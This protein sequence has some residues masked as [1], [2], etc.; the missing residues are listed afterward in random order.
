MKKL[1]T[2]ITSMAAIAL[3]LAPGAAS[4]K[5]GPVTITLMERVETHSDVSDATAQRNISGETFLYSMISAFRKLDKG[6]N[7]NIYFMNKYSID[8]ET[9]VSNIAGVNVMGDITGKWK[10]D[11]GYSHSASPNRVILPYNDSDRFALSA[12]FKV[13]PKEKKHK[14]V[15]FKTSY[16]TGTDFS[17]GRTL[18]Q[19]VQATDDIS[20]KLA[21]TASYQFVWGLSKTNNAAGICS[22]CREHYANQYA[23]DF[24][25]KYSKTNKIVLG[26]QF[27]KNLYNG[28]KSD[29][30]I[31]RLSLMH[32]LKN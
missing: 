13:N 32:T 9:S 16:N 2:T 1:L 18:S 6:V 14:R 8:D 12:T 4:A 23:M 31:W 24:N 11:I 3:L 22:Q 29:D 5:P 25:Y 7:G 20:K 19:K 21:Y 28:A 17:Q 30:S 10:F 15:E 27:L 26:Y